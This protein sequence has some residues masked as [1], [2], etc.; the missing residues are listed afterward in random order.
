MASALEPPPASSVRAPRSPGRSSRLTTTI[1]KFTPP[2]SLFPSGSSVCAAKTISAQR[3]R[4][5]RRGR[6]RSLRARRARLFSAPSALSLSFLQ[7]DR[8]F[9]FHLGLVFD[10]GAHFDNGHGGKVPADDLA[11][12]SADLVKPRFVTLPVGDIPGEPHNLLSFR[13]G[14]FDHSADIVQRVAHLFDEIR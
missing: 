5:M 10:E 13:A 11:I 2:P 14:R 1:R 4:W 12:G 3:T 9:D 7:R 6:R 8:G